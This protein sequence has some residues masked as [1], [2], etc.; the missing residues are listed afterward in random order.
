M[1]ST[2]TFV[3]ILNQMNNSNIKVEF[4]DMGIPKEIVNSVQSLTLR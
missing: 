3:E 4:I 1:D 2:E